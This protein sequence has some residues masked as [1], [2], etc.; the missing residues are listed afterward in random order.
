MGERL[1]RTVPSELAGERL[2]RVV[3]V[4][5][6]MSRSAARLLVESGEVTVDGEVLAARSRL[7]A[8][9]TV[10]FAPPEEI[11]AVAPEPV[12]FGV[13]FDDGQVLVVDKPAGLVVHPGAGH[14]TG[15]LVSGI[16]HLHPEV[17]GVGESGRWG[18]VHRLDRDTSGLM[19]VA[20][21]QEAH[22]GLSE[23]VKART[24]QREYLALVDGEFTVPTGTID[25]PLSRDPSRPTRR[26]LDPTGRPARTH[27]VLEEWYPVAGVSLV[28]VRLETG[29]TH[30]IRVHM[31][32]IDHPLVGDGLYRPGPD[33][34]QVPRMFLH[35]TRLAFT[36]PTTGEALVFESPLPPDLADVIATLK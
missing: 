3:A 14:K 20:V 15:T 1:T 25:A 10:T 31:A 19:V 2:D 35:A 36:H 27:Y 28:R 16:L 23:Q 33:R 5:G 8:G 18:I 24:M 22:A 34:I 13:S 26:K 6:E 17:E 11:E 30:Q 21:T 12:D 32:A 4:L 7:E 9:Q 29:R